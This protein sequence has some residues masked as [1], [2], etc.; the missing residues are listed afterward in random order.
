MEKP[1]VRPLSKRAARHGWRALLCALALVGIGCSPSHPPFAD[2]S[3]FTVAAYGDSLTAGWGSAVGGWPSGLPAA[4][5]RF[6]GGVDSELGVPKRNPDGSAQDTGTNR[7]I[8]PPDFATLASGWRV[9]VMLWGTNDVVYPTYSDSLGPVLPAGVPQNQVL[10]DEILMSSLDRA[11]TLQA[12]GIRVVVA[13]PPPRLASDPS[14]DL[15]NTRLDRMRG[16]LCGRLGAHGV[17]F[18]DLF[19]EFSA[20]DAL[21]DP[22]IYY[23]DAVH[24]NSLGD[25]RAAAVIGQAILAGCPTGF[26]GSSCTTLVD[27][28]ASSPCV[29]GGV[30]SNGV[31]SYTCACPTGYTGVDCETAVDYCASSPCVNG[32][33]AAATPTA[34]AAAARPASAEG[35]ARRPTSRP[36]GVASA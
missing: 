13:W 34:T 10:S 8:S 6:N 20:S 3:R 32:E 14:A 11:A 25:A 18:V 21:P 15:A 17:T 33:P 19:A 30:C 22:S 29:N 4:W 9:V 1:T 23:Q 26:T 28:C 27:Y 24:W 31:G 5:A 36:P 2:P 12:A 16:P 7:P 35:I